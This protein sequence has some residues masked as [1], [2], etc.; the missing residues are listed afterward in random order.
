MA[1]SRALAWGAV[2][3]AG[4]VLATRRRRL[5]SRSYPD[6]GWLSGLGMGGRAVL[7][8]IAMHASVGIGFYGPDGDL[9]FENEYVRRRR[10]EEFGPIVH[11]K[12]LWARL[13]WEDG[14]SVTRAQ[15]DELLRAAKSQPLERLI[16]VRTTTSPTPR[17]VW[18]VIAPV[19]REDGRLLG[20]I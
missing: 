7:H 9:L 12:D 16:H 20:V 11:W 6:G 19:R 13:S 2:A 8:A 5:K 17:I 1:A 3:V 18:F 15:W 14:R 10:G 4:A